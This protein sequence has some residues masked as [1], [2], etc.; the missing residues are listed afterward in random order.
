MDTGIPQPT[1]VTHVDGE[2]FAIRIRSHEIIVDQ[3]IRGG[4]EDSAPT[5]LELLGASLGSCIA[6]FVRRFLVTRELPCD[7]LQV[8]VSHTRATNPSR[9]DAFQ[10]KVTL[11]QDIPQKYMPMIERV[12]ETCPA[13]NT[14]GTGAKIDVEFLEPV[15]V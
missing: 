14:L 11:P 2:K 12:L 10:V 13:H 9:I 15:A 8:D 4:G 7:G 3:T 5:P 1:V 6:F